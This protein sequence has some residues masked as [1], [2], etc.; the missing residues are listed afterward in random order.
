MPKKQKAV[1]VPLK[2]GTFTAFVCSYI[3]VIDYQMAISPYTPNHPP[4]RKGKAV[5]RKEIAGSYS[6]QATTLLHALPFFFAVTFFVRAP[7]FW[8]H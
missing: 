7:I 2:A 8:F 4:L 6:T 3:T 1:P 5:K